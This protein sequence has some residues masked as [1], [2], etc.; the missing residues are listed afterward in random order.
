MTFSWWCRRRQAIQ[1]DTTLSGVNAALVLYFYVFYRCDEQQVSVYLYVA[2]YKCLIWL[3]LFDDSPTLSQ[4]TTGGEV[5]GRLLGSRDETV[6][7]WSVAHGRKVTL[8]DVHA[9]VCDFTMTSD[10]GRIVVRLADS[11]HVPFLC[12]HNSP[13][14]AAASV[15]CHSL[16]ESQGVIGQSISKRKLAYMIVLAD[17]TAQLYF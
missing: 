17:L 11:C 14:A 10:A 15:R 7:V 6:R 13:A 5:L 1:V 9:A 12:L 4:R 8:F 3:W 16:M 2:Q